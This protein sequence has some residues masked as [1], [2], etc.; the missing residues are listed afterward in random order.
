MP[1]G[2]E[3]MI[4]HEAS[5]LASEYGPQWMNIPNSALRN[6]AVRSSGDFEASSLLGKNRNEPAAAASL[7]KSRLVPLMSGVPLKS[8]LAMWTLQSAL[9]SVTMRLMPLPRTAHNLFRAWVLRFPSEF[10]ANFMGAGHQDGGI[11]R[12]TRTLYDPNGTSGD[13]PCD[14]NDLPHAKSE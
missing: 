4:G 11:T 13:P 8:K 1:P 10:V 12:P 7:R 5:T 2:F 9:I 14:L 3:V 6:K